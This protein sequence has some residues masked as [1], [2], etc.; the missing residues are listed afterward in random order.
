MPLFHDVRFIPSR[1]QQANINLTL[2]DGIAPA[3]YLNVRSVKTYI[4]LQTNVLIVPKKP[5]SQ[6]NG[7]TTAFLPAIPLALLWRLRTLDSP[8]MQMQ[9]FIV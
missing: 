9:G 1:W 2:V 4:S 6:A 5:V 8:M 3:I 7:D